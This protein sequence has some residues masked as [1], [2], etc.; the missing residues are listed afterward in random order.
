[1]IETNHETFAREREREREMTSS[2]NV[3]SERKNSFRKTST[4]LCE[5]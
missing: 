3:V 1:M 4:L 5:M 2:A